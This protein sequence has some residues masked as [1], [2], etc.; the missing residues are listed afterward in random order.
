MTLTTQRYQP[1]HKLRVVTAAS[2][3]DGHD[4]AINIMR[5]LIQ[6]GGAEVIHLG[7]NRSVADIVQAAVQED[8]HAIAI[9]SYQGGHNEYFRYVVDLL[10]Q[11]GAGHVKVFGGGGGVIVPDEI[12]DLEAYGVERIYSPEDGRKLGLVGMIDDLIKRSDY[13]ILDQSTLDLGALQRGED[14][15]VGRAITRAEAVH[16]GHPL[17]ADLA[18]LLSTTSAEGSAPVV[19]ITGT[20]GA[21][22]SSLTDELVRRYLEDFTDHRVAVLSVDP[23]RRR[24]GGALLGDRI[25][26][27]IARSER[28]FMRSLAT[29]SSGGAELS[30]AIQDAVRI[31]RA[32]GFELI[33][34]E[35]SGIGQGSSAIVEVSDVHLYVMTPE[36]GAPS[37]LEKI[38]MLDFA[39]LVAINKF[40]RWGAEDALRDVRKQVRRNTGQFQLDAEQ[41]PVFGTVA[42]RFN[43]PGVNSAYLYLLDRLAGH[44]ARPYP[45]ALTAPGSRASSS[46][47]A[48]I[49]TGRKQYL[50]EI[51]RTV[52]AYHEEGAQQAAVA[53]RVDALRRAAEELP[54]D[55][56][57]PLTEKEDALWRELS[58]TNQDRLSA[59]D[60]TVARYRAEEF[61]YTVRGRE[62]RQ[63]LYE[64]SL[65]HLMIPRV[66][67]PRFVD[68]GEQLRWLYRENFAG[69]FPY[70]AGVFP[71]KR[72]GEEPKRMFAGEGGP[73]RTNARF[74]YLCEDEAVARG[75]PPPST[76]SPSTA[77][78]PTS[79]PTSTAR[80][81]RAG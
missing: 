37:Q 19:G 56:R 51:A 58:P 67:A 49:P 71:L 48:L 1:A 4:A 66:A 18:A 17:P 55:L 34:V 75:S 22:K 11:R 7:H 68:P 73:A 40:D 3:F 76:R 53:R 2:L 13:D 74:H 63:P 39:D 45:S 27:N 29:R 78:T 31:C 57:A 16:D 24:T 79:A 81:A 36:Y 26:M 6:S 10:K 59:W 62:I 12:R 9:S 21:G 69:S 41:L 65:S 77:R 25:R 28:C 35:T 50:G 80:S 47:D 33:I 32:A 60:D 54:E 61:I 52:R 15:A 14:L 38:D 44:S 70:T 30:A 46:R 20:G 5:R 42:A 72:K 64:E 8:A 23:T 43:D